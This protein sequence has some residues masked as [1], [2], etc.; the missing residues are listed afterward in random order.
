MKNNKNKETEVM[1]RINAKKNIVKRM[2]G[3]VAVVA[4]IAIIAV[5]SIGGT[6]DA[7]AADQRPKTG[8][9]WKRSGD[10]QGKGQKQEG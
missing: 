5:A 10:E 3:A 9:C 1:A 6:S 2:S 7:Q 4:M 8:F